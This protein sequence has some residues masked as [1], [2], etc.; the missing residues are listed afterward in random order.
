MPL[1]FEP[2]ALAQLTEDAKAMLGRLVPVLEATDFSAAAVDAALRGFAEAEGK[3][4]GQVAQPL[5][6]ALTG[7]TMS[8]GIDVTLEALGANESLARLRAVI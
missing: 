3:K 4:L 8:P 1:P 2:K 7:S 5:R 6:A